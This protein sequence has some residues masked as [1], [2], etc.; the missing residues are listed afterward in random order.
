MAEGVVSSVAAQSLG[1]ALGIAPGDVLLEINGH[2][3]RDV[4]DVQFYSADEA[5]ELLVRQNG[6]EVLYEVE[7]D[8]D[9]PLGIEFESVVFDAMR[10]C[11]ND[12][13]FCFVAQMPPGLRRSLYV[14]DDDY[15]YS[16]L[17]G[18][19]ITLTNMTDEDWDR[20]A[21]QR[22]SPLYVSVHTTDLDLRKRMLRRN[23]LPDILAQ[24]DR[25]AALGIQIHTQIV[26][27][28]GVNDG[29]RLITTVEDL[30]ARHP[31]VQSIGIVPVGLTRYHRGACRPHTP[32]EAREVIEEIGLLQ[33]AL[34]QELGISLVYLADEWYLNTGAQVPAAIEYD[35]YPQLE[36]GIGLVRQFL[37]DCVALVGQ[38]DFAAV[39]RATV[40]CGTLIAPVMVRAVEWLT[41]TL[42]H[43]VIRVVPVVNS[44]FGETVN[45]S[46][47]LSGGDVIQA[48]EGLDLG[49]TVFLPQSMFADGQSK[50]T[51]VLRTLDGLT[52]PDIAERLECRVALA[53]WM[54]QVRSE[55]VG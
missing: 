44:L 21:E 10:R 32:G 13:D 51:M 45:V 40:V 37:D 18:S 9:I 29:P 19:F 33:R 4:L 50:E 17:Y 38:W 22:L 43:A 3:L 30:V 2:A 25:L 12:C 55:L 1:A 27:I 54:S 35:G 8:L 15:R 14:R 23:Q 5:F 16:L 24:I 41:S 20:I 11:R 48:L 28:P 49:E 36:N 39:S 46:G 31:T 34:R 26:L 6:Q 52:V 47:L 42:D 7:R 53:G